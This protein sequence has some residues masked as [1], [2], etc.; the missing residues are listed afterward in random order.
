MNTNKAV[1]RFLNLVAKKKY[2]TSYKSLGEKRARI[3]RNSAVR[4]VKKRR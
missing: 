2:R 4:L 3:V 1:R